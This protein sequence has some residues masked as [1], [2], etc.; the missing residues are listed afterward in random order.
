M[1]LT[2]LVTK[3]SVSKR[4]AALWDI[5]LNLTCSELGVE[6]INKDFTIHYGSG[7]SA[8]ATVKKL[9]V[10]MQAAIDDYKAEQV[11]L[12]HVTLGEG[13]TYLNTYLEG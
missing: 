6:K 2:I 9:Q 8:E 3:K 12:N 10:D 11:I 7:Q 5:T 13:I 4:A 1:A